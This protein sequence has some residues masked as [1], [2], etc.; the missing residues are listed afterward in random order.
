MRYRYHAIDKQGR[1]SRGERNVA[2]HVELEKELQASGLTL[3]QAQRQGN[4]LGVFRRKTARW[5]DLADFC[6]HLSQMLQAGIPLLDSLTQLRNALAA[7]VLADAVPLVLQQIH[8]GSTF[9]QALETHA[10]CF[11]PLLLNGVRAGEAS[12]QLVEVLADLHG[13]F[14][15]RDEVAEQTGKAFYYPVFAATVMLAA[16]LFLLTSV[17]P[18]VQDFVADTGGKLPLAT[19]ALLLATGLLS[20]YGW[21]ILS[22]ALTSLAGLIWAIKTSSRVAAGCDRFLLDL[23]LLGTLRLKSALGQYAQ[24]LGL[25]YDAG[26]PLL[27]ALRIAQSAVTSIQLRALLQQARLR[28]EEGASLGQAFASTSLLPDL[29]MAMLRTGEQTGHLGAALRQVAH[30]YQRDVKLI[31]QRIH[32]LIEPCITV[33]LGGLL[34]WI[35]LAVLGP[36]FDNLG[37]L[38]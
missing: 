36:V 29:L 25:L 26:V 33:V 35:M 28:I 12:G 7:G 24:S 20:H 38:R 23:P 2:S 10:T 4:A 5:R 37:R 1:P 27:D 16:T 6:F 18:Q 8:E 13:Y 9:S 17:M 11:G 31:A 30:Y 3:L 19:R 14:L 34:G 32:S 15:W 22:L 21:A